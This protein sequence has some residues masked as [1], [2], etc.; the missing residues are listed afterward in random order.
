[1]PRRKSTSR[2]RSNRKRHSKRRSRTYRASFARNAVALFNRNAPSKESQKKVFDDFLKKLGKYDG[3]DS[4]YLEKGT[5]KISPYKKY[6]KKVSKN[7]PDIPAYPLPKQN[8][9]RDKIL[10]HNYNS[11]E[12]EIKSRIIETIRIFRS[13]RH[14]PDRDPEFTAILD[15]LRRHLSL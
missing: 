11:F 7:N 4:L 9:Y 3:I 6:R 5:L 14:N 8:I 1:M 2:T 10:I 13:K 12:D 15:D